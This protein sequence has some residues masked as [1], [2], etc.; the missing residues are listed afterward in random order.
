MLQD[1]SQLCIG[2]F[3]ADTKVECTPDGMDEIT[4]LI[5]IMKNVHDSTLS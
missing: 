3:R 1:R 5:A 4:S 2:G